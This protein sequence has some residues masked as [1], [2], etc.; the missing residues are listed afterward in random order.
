MKR[1]MA[2]FAA[3]MLLVFIASCSV[4]ENHKDSIEND[5]NMVLTTAYDFYKSEEDVYEINSNHCKLKFPEKWKDNIETS[6]YEDENVYK[7]SFTA[8]F[9]SESVPLYNFIFGE[10]EDGYLL[11][12][13]MTD[14]GE[15]NVYL[16]DMSAFYEGQL[17]EKNELTYYEMCE[18]VND[19]ISY[20]VYV[21]GMTLAG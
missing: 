5:N 12:R 9:G 16:E 7:V 18:G 6:V 10:T 2:L 13:V 15:Q 1:I 4:D 20:L 17:S 8:V 3:V 19:I 11:G 14:A 21:E